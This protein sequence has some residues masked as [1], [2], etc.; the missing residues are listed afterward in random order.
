[1]KLTKIRKILRQYFEETI[2][3]GDNL[4][5]KSF[6]YKIPDTNDTC[7]VIKFPNCVNFYDIFLYDS[8][9]LTHFL[10]RISLAQ[11]KPDKIIEHCKYIIKR[12]KQMNVEKELNIL[13]REFN[14]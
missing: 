10:E 1:M 7:V 14:Q 2:V 12:Y 4:I 6:I 13:E 8:I 9:F 3:D 11:I 5:D